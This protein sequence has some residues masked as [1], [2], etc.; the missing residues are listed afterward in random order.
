MMFAIYICMLVYGSQSR[1]MFICMC[2]DLLPSCMYNKLN[3]K[4]CQCLFGQFPDDIRCRRS[5]RAVGLLHRVNGVTVT[6]CHLGQVYVTTGSGST[7]RDVL[8]DCLM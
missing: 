2:T 5:R 3:N 8:V 1:I 6:S 7:L 4:S